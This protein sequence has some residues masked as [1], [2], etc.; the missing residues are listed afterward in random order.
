M[1][2]VDTLRYASPVTETVWYVNGREASREQSFEFDPA[3]DGVYTLF[4]TVNGERIGDE[5]TVVAE[6]RGSARDR[7]AMIGGICGG[8]GGAALIAAAIAVA[9]H[10]ARKKKAASGGGNGE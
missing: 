5:V 8:A 4:V 10:C 3:E 6:G 9:V 7:A 2:G 1:L